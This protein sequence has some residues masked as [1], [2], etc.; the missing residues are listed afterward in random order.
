VASGDVGGPPSD[1]LAA[2][3]W[4]LALGSRPRDGPRED[5]PHPDSTQCHGETDRMAISV[6]AEGISVVVRFQ[7]LDPSDRR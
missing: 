3:P 1:T 5:H 6:L 4:A 7:S 2:I